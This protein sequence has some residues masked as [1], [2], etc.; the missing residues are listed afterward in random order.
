MRLYDYRIAPNPRRVRIFVA[1]KG[2]AIPTVQLDL[3]RGENRSP[4][5]LRRNPFGGVPVLELDN[6]TCLAESVAICRYL[7]E[8]HPE[9]RLFGVDPLDRAAVEMW[10]RRMELEIFRHIGG[11]FVHTHEIFRNRIQ[12]LPAYAEMSRAAAHGRMK[13]LDGLIEGRRF[14]AGDRY[15][16]A[17]ITAQCAFGLG[18][19]AGLPID[20]ALKNLARWHA[21]VSARPSA[22]A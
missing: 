5:A 2:I 19:M 18:E 15:T 17:D 22:G 8:L 1:E 14:I 7:E 16:I 12:Q 3:Q 21:E 4:E 10:N 20:P 11:Y 13:L 9:P 6:G